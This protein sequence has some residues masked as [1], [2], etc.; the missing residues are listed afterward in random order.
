MRKILFL[1][2]LV[3]SSTAFAKLNFVTATHAGE[4]VLNNE[5][6]KLNFTTT[7][8]ASKTEV[9]TFKKLQ[10]HIAGSQVVLNVDLSSVDTGIEIRDERLKTLFFNI[11]KFPTAT[12]SI[13]LKKS[14]LNPIK[15][16]QRK[17]L[18]LDAEVT[19]QGVTQT[20]PVEV[21]VITLAQNQRL[22]FSS[23]PI[24]IDL[25]NFNLLKGV[26]Q[27]REIAKLKSINAAVPVT[28][29]LLF[30]KP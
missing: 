8:N 20:I 13:D 16:G 14:D 30:S 27:L 15:Q 2:L 17:T 28:F 21:Q 25:K 5:A 18:M 23:Q 22:V 11:V 3:L 9:Q 12:V 4:W 6:S 10:G 24:I 29:S 1:T 26:N 19:I 7:K